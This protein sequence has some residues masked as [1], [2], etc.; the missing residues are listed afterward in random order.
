MVT[1]RL[2][3]NS[4]RKENRLRIMLLPFVRKLLFFFLRCAISP[5][6]GCEQQL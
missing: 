2:Y 6:A 4:M 3:L 1:L 5:K